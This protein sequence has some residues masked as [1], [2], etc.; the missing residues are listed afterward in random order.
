MKMIMRVT[1][2]NGKIYDSII[3]DY[4]DEEIVAQKDFL[5]QMPDMTYM[6]FATK[7]GTVYFN[8]GTLNNSVVEFIRFD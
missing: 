1:T 6:A 8:K 7:N 3:E 4:N 5:E 2:L